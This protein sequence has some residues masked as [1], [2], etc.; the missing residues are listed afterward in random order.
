LPNQLVKAASA[1]FNPNGPSR[2]HGPPRQFTDGPWQNSGRSECGAMARKKEAALKEFSESLDEVTTSAHYPQLSPVGDGTMPLSAVIHWVA[3][4]GLKREFLLISA[5][6]GY[7]SA[8]KEIQD[9]IVSGKIVVHGENLDGD[10]E[11][12]P[13]IE[14]EDLKFTFDFVE[15]LEDF[16]G[17]YRRIEIGVSEDGDCL[18]KPNSHLSIWTKLVIQREPV[19]RE[20]PFHLV[21]EESA[22]T[23]I[24][25]VPCRGAQAEAARKALLQ[26]FPDGRVPNQLSIARVVDRLN[27]RQKKTGDRGGFERTTVLRALGRKK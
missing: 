19:L 11:A 12:I 14:F 21:T 13:A 25:D 15:G 18:F 3:T 23:S 9:K 26:E 17:H 8:A 27:N 10:R 24:P 7:R 4:E 22:Y 2:L 6:P 1:H 20:W 5:E 16:A